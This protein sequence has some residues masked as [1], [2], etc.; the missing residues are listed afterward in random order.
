METMKSR[1]EMKNDSKKFI[2]EHP[3]VK[4]LFIPMVLITFIVTIITNNINN[5][6]L[7]STE[8]INASSS[9]SYVSLLTIIQESILLLTVMSLVDYMKEPEKFTEYSVIEMSMLPF[10]QAPRYWM[11]LVTVTF[12][13]ILVTMVGLLFLLIPGIILIIAFSQYY[14]FV[15]Y[16]VD[17]EKYEGSLDTLK[18]IWNYMNGYKLDYFILGLSFIG[19]ELVISLFAGIPGFFIYPYLYLTYISFFDEVIKENQK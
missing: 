8:V 7:M 9:N 15:K 16:L 19:W 10:K 17:N 14:L 12:A 2:R 11:P 4:Y 6:Y 1:I 18:L 13:T 5:T 3:K